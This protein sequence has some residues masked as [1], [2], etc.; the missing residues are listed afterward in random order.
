[1]ENFKDS[2]FSVKYKTIDPTKQTKYKESGQ[3]FQVVLEGKPEQNVMKTETINL[4]DHHIKKASLY[5]L[6]AHFHAPSEHSID[7]KP[8]DLE[9]HVV[10][11]LDPELTNANPREKTQFSHGVLG[12]LFRAVKNNYFERNGLDDYHDRF[13]NSI[14][15]SRDYNSKLDLTKFV[16]KLKFHKRWTYQGSLTTTPFSEG[17]LWNVIEQVIPIRQS[18]LDKF[19]EYRKIEES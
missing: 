17:I 11:Q 10:H 5:G 6:Q 19:L 16:Q 13:L 4:F 8:M 14:L 2:N 1:L 3:Q 15:D 18:T 7:G 12:F 9:M